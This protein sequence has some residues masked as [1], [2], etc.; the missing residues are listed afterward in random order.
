MRALLPVLLLLLCPV[1][2]EA[3][4][5]DSL[6]VLV[7][8]AWRGG[9]EVEEGP[10]KVLQVIR[11]VDPDLVLMQESYDI[12]GE[13]PTLGRW[14]AA[15]LGWEAY[16]DKSPHLCVLSPRALDATFFHHAWHGVGVRV[17]D[18]QGRGLVAWSI[19]ID[20]RAFL[21][22]QLRD[23][24]EME[25]AELLKSESERSSRLSQARALL[26][27]VERVAREDPDLPLLVGGDFNCPSHLDWTEDAARVFR[28]RRAL[29]LP[30]SLAM[31]EAGFADT[32]RVV[33]PNPIHRPGITWTPL[34]RGTGAPKAATFER[35]DRLYLRQPQP[36]TAW[37]LAPSDAWTLPR[38]WED[39]AIPTAE[40]TFP[41]DHG[42]L[43]VELEWTRAGAEGTREER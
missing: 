33:H 3:G 38:V 41:S 10:E 27:E 13:R 28:N 22:Y 34:F 1:P 8:N 25:D 2:A 4:D 7:W 17:R 5:G 9:N 14:V 39:D 16:Q 18:E 40:R 32:F 35:I 29:Q 31:V 26:A 37:T 20:Y 19:W 43:V 23:T 21:P 42:A 30:V 24:P 12:D 15:E 36:P 11:D 6:R